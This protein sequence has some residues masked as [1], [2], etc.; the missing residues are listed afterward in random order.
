MTI[1]TTIKAAPIIGLPLAAIAA[2]T[3]TIKTSIAAP[4]IIFS[5]ISII[6]FSSL[7]SAKLLWAGKLTWQKIFLTILLPSPETERGNESGCVRRF[8]FRTGS[9]ASHPRTSVARCPFYPASPQI[10]VGNVRTTHSACRLY[11]SPLPMSSSQTHRGWDKSRNGNSTPG[12]FLP[13]CVHSPHQ[14]IC[15]NVLMWGMDGLVWSQSHSTGNLGIA[16]INIYDPSY[17]ADCF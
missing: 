11:L 2:P 12:A 4:I 14:N 16:N 9:S 15:T 13:E 6:S 7:P 17:R 1:A 5:H 8:Q 10:G 3:I